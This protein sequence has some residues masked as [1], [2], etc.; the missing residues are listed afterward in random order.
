MS[1][2]GLVSWPDLKRVAKITH[3]NVSGM[4]NRRIRGKTNPLYVEQ[5]FCDSLA[6]QTNQF[7]IE[8]RS[9]RDNLL[10]LEEAAVSIFRHTNVDWSWRDLKK[11][12][13]SGYVSNATDMEFYKHWRYEDAR[14]LPKGDGIIKLKWN[15]EPI[16]S[17]LVRKDAIEEL[18][19]ILEKSEPVIP[20]AAEPSTRLEKVYKPLRT[21]YS[22]ATDRSPIIDIPED[23]DE[24]K[25]KKTDEWKKQYLHIKSIY[26]DR[27]HDYLA[28][29]S[30]HAPVRVFTRFATSEDGKPRLS[31]RDGTLHLTD[32]ELVVGWHYFVRWNK[33]NVFGPDSQYIL[34][35]GDIIGIVEPG[36]EGY[37]HKRLVFSESKSS[38]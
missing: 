34:K 18:I 13:E 20:K 15:E 12:L 25:D 31:G 9:G 11:V 32:R 10:F 17:P 19:E 22:E 27:L 26:I 4:V 29:Y 23:K 21:K 28:K 30:Y 37:R 14:L 7:S 16:A 36:R 6:E 1:I 24:Q 35:E 3:S 2:E 33:D 8:G 5:A 38:K